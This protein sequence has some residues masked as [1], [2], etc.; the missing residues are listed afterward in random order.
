MRFADGG[1]KLRAVIVVEKDCL[2]ANG[3]P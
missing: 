1:D 3:I 2:G